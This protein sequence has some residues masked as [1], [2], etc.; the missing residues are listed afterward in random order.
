M[1]SA[2]IATIQSIESYMVS[3]RLSSKRGTNLLVPLG[4]IILHVA[5]PNNRKSRIKY[6]FSTKDDY[7][8][9]QE[10]HS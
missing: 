9:L 1:F 10:E 8:K 5:I 4:D 7:E 2:F 3:T 6:A